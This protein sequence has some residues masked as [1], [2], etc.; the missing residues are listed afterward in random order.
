VDDA[1]DALRIDAPAATDRTALPVDE[2]SVAELREGLGDAGDNLDEVG[3]ALDD[4]S[5]DG[6]P[7]LSDTSGRLDSNPGAGNTF[8]EAPDVSSRLSGS[9]TQSA[10]S[11]LTP[12]VG[13]DDPG[14][15]DADPAEQATSTS[16]GVG[17]P[18][19]FGMGETGSSSPSDLRQTD[20]STMTD[21]DSGGSW[22][23]TAEWTDKSDSDGGQTVEGKE[24]YEMGDGTTLEVET[25]HEDGVTRQ[26]VTLKDSEGNVVAEETTDDSE[27][28]DDSDDSDT[29]APA[30]DDGT[31]TQT[32]PDA[33]PVDT[34]LS[35]REPAM[36]DVI[37]LGP[38]VEI[39]SPDSLK[40]GFVDDDEL[41]RPTDY[42]E[43]IGEVSE[44]GRVDPGTQIME[45]GGDMGDMEGP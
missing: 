35:G 12:T 8:G 24:T 31:A 42:D 27:E 28:S 1:A 3:A 18:T 32:A 23:G 22:R 9:D 5:A 40:P 14:S 19:G 26:E 21:D 4:A 36:G 41:I 16:R 10:E 38:E 44:F 37:N 15:G 13:L 6:P 34:T 7:D 29:P 11:D 45:D 17:D 20:N 2:T 39:D 30:P 43:P 33:D 25:S